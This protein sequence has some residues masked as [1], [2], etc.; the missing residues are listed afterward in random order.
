[1]EWEIDVEF[2]DDWL[3][4][5]DEDTYDQVIAALRILQREGPDLGRPLV[6]SVK[7]S[8]HHR[9]KELRPGSS[10]SSEIRM[11]FVFD[12]QRRGIILVAGDKRGEWNKWYRRNI[13]IA[14][15]RYDAHLRSLEK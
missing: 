4:G 3:D 5:L 1:M 13:P 7:G 9:M 8:R 2:I 14:D 10:G 15:A 6:D 12:P 11:L